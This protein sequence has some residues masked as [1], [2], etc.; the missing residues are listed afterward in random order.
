ME[1]CLQK[2]LFC[3]C[4]SSKTSI[5]H[6]RSVD[7]WQVVSKTTPRDLFDVHGDLENGEMENY[8]GD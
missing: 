2:W 6:R 4:N 3:I 8:L 1:S 5:L 7:N